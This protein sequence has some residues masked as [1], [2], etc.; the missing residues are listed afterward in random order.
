MALRNEA[1]AVALLEV[2]VDEY[3]KRHKHTLRK[4]VGVGPELREV[5]SATGVEYD[6]EIA[7]T[8]VQP[9][10]WHDQCPRVD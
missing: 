8:V 4:Q 3:I 7:A 2:Q 9:P 5:R 10:E 6:V 1:E